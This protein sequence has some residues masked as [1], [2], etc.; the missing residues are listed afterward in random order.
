MP[1]STLLFL[2]FDGVIC[3][4]I[5]ECFVSSWL[6]YFHYYLGKKPFSINLD[7]KSRFM[8]LRPFIRTGSDYLLIQELL[9]KHIVIKNQQAFDKALTWAGEKNM[10]RYGVLFYKARSYLLEHEKQYWFSLN[11][12]YKHIYE[13]FKEYALN[14]NLYI[15]STKREDYIA[16]ILNY[17]GIEFL[18]ENIIQSKNKRKLDMIAHILKQK[19]INKAI[20]LE[21]Q[22]DHLLPNPYPYIKTLLVTWGYIKKEWLQQKKV[23]MIDKTEFI[24]LFKGKH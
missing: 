18:P 24:E 11:P 16:E 23:G 22:I 4:S 1:D 5:M 10:K 19:G 8:Q 20:L 14:D 2:D 13:W 9:D 21:D 12:L 6:A 3:D 15:L 7:L 17:H